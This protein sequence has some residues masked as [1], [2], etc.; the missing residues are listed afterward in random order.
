MAPYLWRII[1][2]LTLVCV[3]IIT[4][5]EPIEDSLEYTFQQTDNTRLLSTLE[6]LEDAQKT[7]GKY[8]NDTGEAIDLFFGRD[9]TNVTF[10][11]SQLDILLP[12][13]LYDSGNLETSANVRAQ[14]DLPRTHYRW[15]LFIASFEQTLVDTP[16]TLSSIGES[17][18]LA[19]TGT[20]DDNNANSLGA[21]YQLFEMENT[22]ANIDIGLNASS[23]IEYSPF[24]RVKL[25]YRKRLTTELTSRLTQN[26]FWSTARGGALDL[27]QTF[28]FD[29]RKDILL[30]SQTAAIWWN[31]D[32][33]TQINQKAVLFNKLNAHRVH[34]Y[35]L[36]GQWDNAS[37][38]MQ[39][40]EL[41][42]GMNWREKLYK[43]W[44]FAELEPK[45]T[46]REDDGFNQPIAS[47]LLMLE[48]RFYHRH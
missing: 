29:Y 39:F 10:K 25:R 26:T 37:G 16:Q 34:A 1:I 22:K 31:D 48:M 7:M 15:K 13:V 28:D 33:Y 3:P 36:R 32:E 38:A 30:R 40:Q 41:A 43:E 4:F 6:A 17:T 45:L 42:T 20:L 27:K 11:G 47:V 12:V 19:N 2:N 21:L 18:N 14:I 46:W 44:L 5:A 35:Y 23:L 8:V 24:I 9:T